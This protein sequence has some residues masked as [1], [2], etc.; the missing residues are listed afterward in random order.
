LGVERKQSPL[1]D[2]QIRQPEQ[3]E[4]LCRVLGQSLVA[5]LL[6][7]KDIFHDM[8]RVLDLRSDAGLD[9]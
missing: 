9:C 2:Q 6:H 1:G 5:D 8:E 7:A 4:Q 3:G